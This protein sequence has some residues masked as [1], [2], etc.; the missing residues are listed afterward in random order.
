M[1]SL[2]FLIPAM[3][4]GAATARAQPESENKAAADAAYQR[5][6]DLMT[7]GQTEAA[8]AEFR[9]SYQLDPQ[10]GSQYNL[11]LC[12]QKLGKL[13]SAY[14]ELSE[15]AAKDTNPKRRARAHEL[16]AKLAPRLTRLTLIV[17]DP[18]PQLTVRRDRVD[19][20]LLVGVT[21]PVDPGIYVF[22]AEAPA[23]TP[24][25]QRVDL[26]AEGAT[27]TVEIPA[28]QPLGKGDDRTAP[29]L[30]DGRRTPGLAAPVR[31]GR[32][33]PPQRGTSG[34]T[35]IAI[36]AAGAGAVV[37]GVGFVFG[38]QAASLTQ[39]A[40]EECGGS[41]GACTGSLPDAQSMIDD[42][43]DKANLSNLFV[44]VGVAAVATGA[45][46]WLTRPRAPREEQPR[47][48]L[49]PVIDP[50]SAGVVVRGYF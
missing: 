16:A 24:W 46:L 22:R 37:I 31:V 21:T 9:R 47:A 8:C 20:T 40:E 14:G 43:R 30:D 5:G 38:A 50:R 49:V 36:G 25:E 15:L 48:Q 2:L 35:L 18:A 13:A 19:I 32:A 7:Q 29:G 11:A 39:D 27:I 34:R 23:R 42:A 1:R 4:L 41:L 3:L 6:R 12:Y 26:S 17:T 33:A 28:L 45:V 44:G 10:F